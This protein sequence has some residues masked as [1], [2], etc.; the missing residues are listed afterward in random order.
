MFPLAASA[1]RI[2]KPLPNKTELARI[3]IDEAMNDSSLQI[4]DV[5]ATGKSMCGSKA[6]RLTEAM[7]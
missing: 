5:I 3:A 7:I 6:S 4:G 1:E 2:K